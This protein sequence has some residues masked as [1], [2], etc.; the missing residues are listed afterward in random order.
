[1]NKPNSGKN[2]DLSLQIDELLK[3]PPVMADRGYSE[4]TTLLIENEMKQA[5]I[6]FMTIAIIS[7]VLTLCLVSVLYSFSSPLVDTATNAIINF[8]VLVIAES[9]LS[10]VDISLL[11]F[12]LLPLF[13]VGIVRMT[14]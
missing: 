4:A 6:Q 5:K 10:I 12:A 8:N 2:H 3:S 9:I 14:E 11:A 13:C 1:V 7:S